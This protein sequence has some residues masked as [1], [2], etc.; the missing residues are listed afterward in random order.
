MGLEPQEN[1]KRNSDLYKDYK[2]GLN[3]VELV[4]KYRISSQRIYQIIKKYEAKLVL[5]K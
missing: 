2:S 1:T 4:S 3:F 5:D